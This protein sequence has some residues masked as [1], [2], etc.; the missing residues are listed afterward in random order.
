[1]KLS[2]GRNAL[3][4][5]SVLSR[6]SQY[7]EAAAIG[8]IADVQEL[9]ASAVDVGIPDSLSRDGDYGD[10]DD[11]IG[12][13]AD[14]TRRVKTRSFQNI[15]RDDDDDDHDG[16]DL[17]Y[18][19]VD[20]SLHVET[21]GTNDGW[22]PIPPKVVPGQGNRRHA[23]PTPN[24]KSTDAYEKDGKDRMNELTNTLR[25]KT[26]DVVLVDDHKELSKFPK[27]RAFQKLTEMPNYT[28]LKKPVTVHD[29][30]SFE[31][32]TPAELGFAYK[33]GDKLMEYATVD[34]DQLEK[35]KDG[36]AKDKDGNIKGAEYPVVRATYDPD[37]KYI[38]YQEA[39]KN[40]QPEEGDKLPIPEIGMQ[41]FLDFTGDKAK[42]LKV[43]LLAN[44]K[45]EQTW[46][47]TR[48]TYNELKIKF[49]QRKTFEKGTKEFDR[50]VG[51][52]N[53]G[54]KFFG[55]GNHHNAIGNKIPY[56]VTIV[57]KQAVGKKDFD[58]MTIAVFFEDF[59]G[60]L[61]Y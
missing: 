36:W 18:S 51:S 12:L 17:D 4:L 34:T 53:F 8:S 45:N 13:Y 19:Y 32:F 42:H 49:D 48:D 5:A 38:I 21:R 9:Q 56:K 35:T 30:K 27:N 55:Y 47:M 60:Y 10:E 15:P 39:Y 29:I 31:A 28:I 50:F 2:S 1:M 46:D 11:L 6:L 58:E 52:P 16:D 61:I 20:D 54:S 57:P 22:K 3:L 26:S 40:T 23:L 25:S 41:N 44:I 7:S 59:K 14:A 33:P 24:F 37:G 43:A